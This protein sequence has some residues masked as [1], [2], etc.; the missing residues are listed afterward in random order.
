MQAESTVF[1]GHASDRHKQTPGQSDRKINLVFPGD[2]LSV[3]RALKASMSVL[4]NLGLSLNEKGVVEI[5]LAE[6][7]NNVVEHAFAIR[8][9]VVE[10][11]MHRERD[12]LLFK[13]IDDGLPMPKMDLPEGGIHDL[14]V[15]L[16]SLPEGGFGWHM[17]KDL[18]QDLQYAHTGTRNHLEFKI[19][20][21]DTQMA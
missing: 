8:N 20:L 5:V 9:G 2:L 10:L 18:T 19:R 13:V 14:N 12:M 4:Q 15:P 1:M 7:L 17:I 21:S 6:V 3:R 11:R 16:E